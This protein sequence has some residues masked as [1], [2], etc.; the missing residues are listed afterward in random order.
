MPCGSG[1]HDG[2]V[3]SRKE[4]YV[5][6]CGGDDYGAIAVHRNCC[7]CWKVSMEYDGGGII[8]LCSSGSIGLANHRIDA[9]CFLGEVTGIS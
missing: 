3:R 2:H 7:V 8:Y 5:Y 1:M 4:G 6:G 9:F